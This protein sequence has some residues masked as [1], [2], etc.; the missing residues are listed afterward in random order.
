M[1]VLKA[2]YPRGRVLPG[3][4]AR[5]KS[6]DWSEM[7]S[8]ARTSD[9]HPGNLAR[10]EADARAANPGLSDD[11]VTRLAELARSDYFS[12]LRRGGL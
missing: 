8:A 2:A 6:E 12:R 4:I 1:P 10:Y 5:L 11:Q 7:T 9:R 3:M